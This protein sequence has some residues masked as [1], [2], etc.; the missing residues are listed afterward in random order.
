MHAPFERS[1]TIAAPATAVWAALT[2]PAQMKQWM[3]EPEMDLDVV[4]DWVVGGPIEVR[5]FLHK[6]FVNTGVVVVCDPPRALRYTHLSSISRLPDVPE[7]YTTLDFRLAPDGAQTTL[8]VTIS[9]FPTT[10]IFKHLDFYWRGTLSI[11]QR[12]VEAR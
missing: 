11:L 6:R 10:S 2:E 8:T 3:G 5:G 12:F 4:T 1:V 9:G 7:S